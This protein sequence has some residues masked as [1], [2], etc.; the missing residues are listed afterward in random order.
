MIKSFSHK[1]IRNFFRTGTTSG[2]QTNH[3]ARIRLIL[4]NLDVAEKPEDMDL[5]GLALHPLTGGRKTFWAVKVSRN[6]RITFRFDE[7]DAELVDYVD[8]H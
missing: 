3:A 6:W 4:T 8:Y 7:H 5:P 1:G 2:I